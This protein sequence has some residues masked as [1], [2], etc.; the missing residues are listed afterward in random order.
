MLS[1][2]FANAVRKSKLNQRG[3]GRMCWAGRR[4]DPN[5]QSWPVCGTGIGWPLTALNRWPLYTES[6]MLGP[7][8]KIQ[9]TDKK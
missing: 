3:R 2:N 9:G 8:G 7:M 1:S 6:L 5:M 4:P